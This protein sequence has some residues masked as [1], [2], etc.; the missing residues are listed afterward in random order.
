VRNENETSS[1]VWSDHVSN[2]PKSRNVID[3][4]ALYMDLL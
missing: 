4:Q 2:R 3:H 1:K